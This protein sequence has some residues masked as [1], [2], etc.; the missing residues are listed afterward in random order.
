MSSPTPSTSGSDHGGTGAKPAPESV[1]ALA[2]SGLLK[3]QRRWTL[4]NA[5]DHPQPLD[6]PRPPPTSVPHQITN[7]LSR[8]RLPV[9][10]EDSECSN[11]PSD[12]VDWSPAPIRRAREVESGHLRKN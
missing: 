11:V 1:S 4:S 6:E 5:I 8:S 2:L 3:V 10:L 12:P 9:H 7:S